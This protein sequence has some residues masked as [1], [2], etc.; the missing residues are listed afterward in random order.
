MM[1]NYFHRKAVKKMD[2]CKT[3]W[4]NRDNVVIHNDL[5]GMISFALL[6]K[7]N[8][9]KTLVGFYDLSKIV[10]FQNVNLDEILFLDLDMDNYFC[11]GHHKKIYYSDKALNP[12]NLVQFSDYTNKYPFNTFMFLMYLLDISMEDL[13]PLQRC[14]IFTAD[15]VAY[16]ILNYSKNVQQW[17]KLLKLNSIQSYQMEREYVG[18]VAERLRKLTG[19]KKEYPQFKFAVEDKEKTTKY[20]KFV[21]EVFKMDLQIPLN[22][23]IEL[24]IK[25]EKK[26]GDKE[27]FQNIVKD[28][29][30][31][32]HSLIYRNTV[33]YTQVVNE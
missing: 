24:V 25:G 19:E 7:Y 30:I 20:L 29:N 1:T 15:S 21:E 4:F 23:N 26:T 2:K 22:Y 6:K 27:S 13:S 8:N 14:L 17:D 12:N 18:R 9:K 5:D 31:L 3:Q 11:I 28:E 10:L 16:N 32:S 33:S